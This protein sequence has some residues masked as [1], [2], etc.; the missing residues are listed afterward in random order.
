MEDASQLS[1]L[2]ETLNRKAPWSNPTL[3][4]SGEVL[5]QKVQPSPDRRI[6]SLP[7]NPSLPYIFCQCGKTSFCCPILL[8]HS[9]QIWVMHPYLHK[10]VVVT[11]RAPMR[12]RE[13]SCNTASPHSPA[14]FGFWF[15]VGFFLYWQRLPLKSLP[16]Y[17]DISAT[18]PPPYVMGRGS[19][20]A[21]GGISTW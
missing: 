5:H 8:S 13:G 16:A 14:F 12:R 6:I 21:P 9:I 1:R 18:L 19:L 10:S 11:F 7:E 3:G 2:L 15:L 20:G 17:L 4:L